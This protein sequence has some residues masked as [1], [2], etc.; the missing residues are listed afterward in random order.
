[1]SLSVITRDSNARILGQQRLE[2][3]EACREIQPLMHILLQEL[4]QAWP[5][6]DGGIH[7]CVGALG[8]RTKTDEVTVLLVGRQDPAELLRHLR[9]G[10]RHDL[11]H[12]T[13]DGGAH[14]DGRILTALGDPARQHDVTIKNGA[15]GIRDRVLL[16]IA[17][18]EY[19]VEGGDGA[20]AVGPVAGALDQLRQPGEDR[21]RIALGRRRLAD[22][23]PDLALRLA[24]RVR[25]SMSSSTLL[26]WS[27]KYS[28]IGGGE[29]GAVQAHQRR[30][31]GRRG[32]DHRAARSFGPEDIARRIP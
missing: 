8:V 14:V 13:A 28:A 26:P 24:K 9:M 10:F 12:G 32:D 21:G 3:C 22:G 19:G 18:G 20:A 31:V 1:M 25:E 11:V 15:R 30:V 27:R 29:P 5:Q 2:R 17:F 16:V 7:P 6:L 23:Q 4:L